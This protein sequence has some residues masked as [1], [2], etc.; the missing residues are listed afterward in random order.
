MKLEVG[1]T[2]VTNDGE[3]VTMTLVRGDIVCSGNRQWRKGGGYY[4]GPGAIVD[5]SIKREA[6]TPHADLIRAVLDGKV[7]QVK[8]A[9]SGAWFDLPVDK[10]TIQRLL[11]SESLEFRLKP[12]P[13]VWWFPITLFNNAL[14]HN[15]AC[16]TRED[17]VGWCEHNGEGVLVSL[18]RV[19][20][21]P[22]NVALIDAHTEAP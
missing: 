22:D 4:D 9:S 20:L 10:D 18:L 17:A 1:K 7:V 15:D 6:A 11:S 5:K 21:D 2:Y 14:Q 3:H 13:V 8:G 12:E 19:E 16:P